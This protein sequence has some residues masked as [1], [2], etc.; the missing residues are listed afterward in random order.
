MYPNSDFDL[1]GVR[2]RRHRSWG[3]AA[4][5]ATL[6][7]TRALLLDAP[8]Q[9]GVNVLTYHNDN[10]RTGQNQDETVLSPAN[11]APNTFGKLFDCPVDGYV[12][13]QPLYMSGV[14]IP[15][16]GTHNVVFVATEHDSVYAFDADTSQGSTVAP[17]WQTRL[18]DPNAGESPVPITDY[19]LS[20]PPEEG[21]TGT[22]V[23]DPVSGTLYVVAKIKNYQTVT[24]VQRLF[25]L[26]VATGT[27]KFGGP[28]DIAASVAGSGDGSEGSGDVSFEPFYEFQRPGLLLLNGVVYVT[29]A[30]Q[31][32]ITPYHGWV[33]G[34]A[35]QSLQL[36]S[37]FNDT[38][39]GS[40]G[41]IWMSGAGPASDS[42]GSLYLL[43]GNGT[44]DANSGGADY[45]D[46]FVKLVSSG[47]SLRPVD[48]FTPYNQTW[49]EANDADL[50]SGGALVLPDAVGSPAH[51]HLVV[52]AGKNGTIYLLDRDNLGQYHPQGDTQIVQEL[53]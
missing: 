53:F 3:R 47:S 35:A 32:D 5:L 46:S 7:L 19:G 18:L 21:V 13:A 44:F 22:P 41:G 38:P 28:V 4:W 17:L 50:G 29:F 9:T 40:D 14:Q 26:D 34:Y 51:P 6:V 1:R 43:T 48:Y 52:G 15:G 37:A 2:P 45:G 12:Y 25:A 27:N 30:S 33:L 23:I 24:Y 49:M 42:S 31:G 39:N 11:V 10:A 8:A 16:Q 36:V 20:D